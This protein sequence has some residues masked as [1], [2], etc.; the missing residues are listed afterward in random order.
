MDLW[1]VLSVGI[2]FLLSAVLCPLLIPMLKKLKFGQNIREE[3]NPEHK[4]KQGTPTMVAIAY[5]ASF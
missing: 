1:N 5:L 3:G 4:K 2:A